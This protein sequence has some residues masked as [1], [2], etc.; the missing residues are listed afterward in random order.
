VQAAGIPELTE[1]EFQEQVV[2]LARLSGWRVYHT[3]LAVRSASGFPDL[4]LAR[5]GRLVFA[6]LKSNR[7]KLTLA[8]EEWL[9][10]LRETGAAEVYLWRP[11]DWD[12]I[13][14]ILTWH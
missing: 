13:V 7:G 11:D 14:Q 6:E 8:Q 3:W 12:E 2:E 5:P 9:Q 1:K 4:V 10:A